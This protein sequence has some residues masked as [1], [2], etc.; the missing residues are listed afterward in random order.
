MAL[1]VFIPTLCPTFSYNE[2]GF[3]RR[4]ALGINNDGLSGSWFLFNRMV[5]FNRCNLYSAC[6]NRMQNN[7]AQLPFNTI[8]ILHCK[9]P[10]YDKWHK[11]HTKCRWLL[12]RFLGNMYNYSISVTQNTVANK[13]ITHS[14]L[15]YPSIYHNVDIAT[16]YVNICDKK[17]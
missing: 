4:V 9:F 15:L 6:D 17:H 16:D 12:S 8:C 7:I 1:R 5:C 14:C 10:I 11:W 13:P 3:Q 2:S